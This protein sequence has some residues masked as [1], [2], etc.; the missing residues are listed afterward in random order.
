MT[1]CSFE[2]EHVWPAEGRFVSPEYVA[3]GTRVAIGEMIKGGTTCFND[4]Y[5]FPDE[6]AKAAHER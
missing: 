2:Q 5:F 3:D 4:M 6:I 1:E